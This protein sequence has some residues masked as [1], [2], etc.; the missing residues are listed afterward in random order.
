[1]TVIFDIVALELSTGPTGTTPVQILADATIAM[2]GPLQAS[3]ASGSFSIADHPVDAAGCS[4]PRTDVTTGFSVIVYEV[5]QGAILLGMTSPQWHYNIVCPGVAPIRIPAFGEESLELFLRD[6]MTPYYVQG[7]T[8]VLLPLQPA[9]APGC[10][11][12]YGV[13]SHSGIQAA[14]ALVSIYVHGQGCSP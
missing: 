10:L 6:L 2:A 9:A 11:K 14:P 3:A 13:F 12:Q 7:G 8:A 4:W 5:R 1:M